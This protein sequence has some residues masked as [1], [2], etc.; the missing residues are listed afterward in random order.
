MADIPV[1]LGTTLRFCLGL[2]RMHGAEALTPFSAYLA[3][4]PGAVSLRALECFRASQ[5]LG[6]RDLLFAVPPYV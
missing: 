6:Q 2:P 1:R 5:K 3:F 4:R